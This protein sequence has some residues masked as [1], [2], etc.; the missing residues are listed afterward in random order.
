MPTELGETATQNVSTQPVLASTLPDHETL[1]VIDRIVTNRFL[2]TV[3]GNPSFRC[4]INHCQLGYD[5]RS[6]YTG[7]IAT[8]V[9]I[10]LKRKY[11]IC[12]RKNCPAS[13][14][15]VL[16]NF[17]EENVLTICNSSPPSCNYQYVR[18]HSWKKGAKLDS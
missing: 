9:E 3:Q 8:N 11:L 1:T 15:K 13:V 5:F 6:F 14:H 17:P 16:T 18:P 10:Q 2:R 7:N 12:Q 4:S